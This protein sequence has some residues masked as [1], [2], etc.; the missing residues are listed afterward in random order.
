MFSSSSSFIFQFSNEN[1]CICLQIQGEGLVNKDLP[2][3]WECPK[4]VQGITD[5]EVHTLNTQTVINNVSSFL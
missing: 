3:C 1:I 2:S 4:C 5:P